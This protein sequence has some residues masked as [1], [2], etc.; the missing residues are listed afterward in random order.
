MA[1]PL[2]LACSLRP[3]DAAVSAPVQIAESRA[4]NLPIGKCD[5][6][7]LHIQV[8]PKRTNLHAPKHRGMVVEDTWLL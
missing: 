7:G 8:M 1:P 2:F 5:V 4:I 6:K 3:I